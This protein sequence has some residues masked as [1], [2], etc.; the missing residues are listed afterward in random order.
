MSNGEI[1]E[2]VLAVTALR[3]IRESGV[4]PECP[5]PAEA[6]ERVDMA[7][8]WVCPLC[9]AHTT[10]EVLVQHLVHDGPQTAWRGRIA[11]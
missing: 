4:A 7:D 11:L 9:G 2:T 10:D 6:L 1:T 8:A 3:I 5:H